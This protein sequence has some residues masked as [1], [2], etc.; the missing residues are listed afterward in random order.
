MLFSV[1]KNWWTVALVSSDFRA[2]I[3]QESHPPSI[4][5]PCKRILAGIVID[6]NYEYQLLIWLQA[7]ISPTHRSST[8]KTWKTSLVSFLAT[9]TYF[10]PWDKEHY[11]LQFSTFK[12]WSKPWT[13][14]PKWFPAC[15]QALNCQKK[16]SSHVS[17]VRKALFKMPLLAICSPSSRGIHSTALHA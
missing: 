11:D 1:V 7:C 10:V 9:F 16:Q 14:E 5:G 13:R 4:V 2:I 12:S 15:H 6:W 8:L 17:V 3:S